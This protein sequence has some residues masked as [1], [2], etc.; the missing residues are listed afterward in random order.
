[1]INDLQIG[2]HPVLTD[3]LVIDAT[4]VKNPTP[5]GSVDVIASDASYRLLQPN[6]QSILLSLLF[7]C[8]RDSHELAKSTFQGHSIDVGSIHVTMGGATIKP[9]IYIM[10]SINRG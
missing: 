8:E 4:Q 10:N 1:M 7:C 3:N 2:C 9:G 5:P 6:L